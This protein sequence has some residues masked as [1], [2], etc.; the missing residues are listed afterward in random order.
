MIGL[1]TH[2][3]LALDRAYVTWLHEEREKKLKR[4]KGD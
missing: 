3:I 4:S 1:F 2:V